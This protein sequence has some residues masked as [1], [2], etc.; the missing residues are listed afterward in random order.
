MPE[1][2][3][4]YLSADGGMVGEG[5]EVFPK[6]LMALAARGNDF[7]AKIK[8]VGEFIV[9]HSGK[10]FRPVWIQDLDSL[11]PPD[12]DCLDLKKYFSQGGMGN[13][14]TKRGGPF[15][16]I[17]CTYPLIEGKKMR[18]RSP[19][20]VAQEAE[21]LIQR[22]VENAFIV[23]NIF[24]YPET[25]AREVCRIFIEKRICLSGL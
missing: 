2:I 23:D 21:A 7:P 20:R 16:C 10:P 8:R 25:H 14:Q 6:A 3:I 9:P 15:G 17:Y 1:A 22:G 12:W 13:L 18:L 4:Q 24:N 5:E 11:P 19:G